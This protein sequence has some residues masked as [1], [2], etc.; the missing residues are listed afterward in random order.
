MNALWRALSAEIL[1]TKRTLAMWMI[2]IAPS[3]VCVLDFLMLLNQRINNYG[4]KYDSWE[5]FSRN[6]I[7]IWSILMLPLF[8]TLETALLAN[9]EHSEKQ[10]KHLFALPLPRWA[11]Y[12]AKWLVMTGMTALSMLVLVGETIAIGSICASFIPSMAFSGAGPF[13][14]MLKSAALVFLVSSLI[15]SI[16]TWVALHWKSF[17][18]AVSFGMVMTVANLL[19]MNSEKWS[20]YFPWSLAMHALGAYEQQSNLPMALGLGIGGG[21]LLALLGCWEVVRRDVL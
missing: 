4:G 11:T 3:V 2:L 16:H 5:M 10:W 8:V 19:V 9:M 20:L 1:K 7:N 21:I 14:S 13:A 15:I 17:T 18:V 6:N 12:L